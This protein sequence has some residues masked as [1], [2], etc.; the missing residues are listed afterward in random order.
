[1]QS[2]GSISWGAPA[3]IDLDLKNIF[4]EATNKA[5]DPTNARRI[6]FLLLGAISRFSTVRGRR[7]ETSC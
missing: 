3:D 7:C 6:A 5:V 1:M 2:S 4:F